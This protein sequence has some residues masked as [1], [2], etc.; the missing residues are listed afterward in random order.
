MTTR[1][2]FLKVSLLAGSALA[3]GFRFDEA[4]ADDGKVFQP[5]AWVRIAA[6]GTVTI[7]VGKSE[8]G[9][10]VR[11]S[12][13]MILAEEL[14]AD[15]T[16]VRLE[17]ASPGPQYRSLGTGGSFS[18]QSQWKPLRQAGATAR[19]L[20]LTAAAARLGV[21]R[22]SLRAERGFVVS[23]VLQQRI[24]YG[25][26][27]AAAAALPVPENVP[28]KNASEF[29]IIGKATRRLDG[30]D[31][32]TGRA[33]YG[34][35]VRVPRMRYATVVRPPVLGGSVKSFDATRA[36]KIAGVRAV[37]QVSTGVA[38]I[39]DHTWAA[40]KGR[41]ALDVVFDA[42]PN[43][44]F[45]SALHAQRM[46]EAAAQPGFT[47][48]KDGSIS[49]PVVKRIESTYQYPFYAH[50]PVETMNTVAD[51]R[52]DRCEL[53]SPTQAPQDVRKNVATLL[54]IPQDNVTVHVTLIGGGFG[55][56][57]GWDYAVE[58]AEVSKAAGGGPVQVLWSRADD[59][60]HGY[61]Q[62]ASLHQMSAG[63]DADGKL[64]SWSHKKV[65]SP[66]NA[67][68]KPTAEQMQDPTFF[69]DI[70]WGVYDVPY[71]I[72]FI[73]TAYLPVATPVPIGP[74]RAVFS[75]SS[76]FARESFLDELAHAAGLDPIEFR[77]AH[78]GGAEKLTAGDVT[79]DRPRL[80]RVLET[81]R[82][83]SDWG[84][85]LPKGSGRGMACNVY[86]G[87][88]HV[89]YSAE[90]TVREGKIRVDRVVCV[91]DCGVVVNPA[92]I[93]AQVEGG[94]I[95]SLSSALKSELTFRNGGA[96][97]SSYRDFEVLRIDEAPKIEVHLIPSHGDTP[98][99]AGEPPVPPMVPALVNAIHAA[100]GKRVRKL[101]IR[102]EDL[103]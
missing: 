81:L 36:K 84:K 66:H 29:R 61:F 49:S 21:E 75:P 11:T 19:E 5:N 80:R 78:L 2:E 85:P 98:F 100:T 93:E 86:D 24:P 71:D 97:Q 88:T 20:L 73:E 16:K 18:V 79:I 91:F 30:H 99:G 70:S 67:R 33:R 41:E 52:G 92:G 37:V 1:R 7:V 9:Q 59:M 38:V 48:R 10:G 57:L 40:L 34:I 72:P 56:R 101:P 26:L 77:L 96:E 45:S 68:S 55:R 14:E 63:F 87:D 89:A 28:L 27:V 17:Q 13:P 76:T 42:G 83:K 47:T 95:W 64:V 43:A 44:E 69:R 58:A 15:W 32:V 90:V 22:A 62:A 74:W 39:A 103:A 4:D 65:S 82:A 6:D 46:R 25:E 53:W 31:I 50:A 23:D 54:G 8:M 94:V 35:D 51:V 60:K 102:A 3:I 12:L